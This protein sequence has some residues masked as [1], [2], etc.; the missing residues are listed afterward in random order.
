MDTKTFSKAFKA[1]IIFLVVIL[2]SSLKAKWRMQSQKAAT[3]GFY[4]IRK[5]N[6]NS[7]THV[8]YSENIPKARIL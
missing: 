1:V 6:Q 7:D 5:Q 2:Q 3:W 8:Y 4:F